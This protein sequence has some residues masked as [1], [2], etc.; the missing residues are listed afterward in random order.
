MSPHHDGSYK[1]R[2]RRHN[3]KYKGGG[4]TSRKKKEMVK[5]AKAAGMALHIAAYDAMGDASMVSQLQG[6]TLPMR[7]P[8]RPPPTPP[9][10]P[11]IICDNER[12]NDLNLNSKAK[13]HLLIEC[14]WKALSNNEES[15]RVKNQ[16][17]ELVDRAPVTQGE[18]DDPN[19]V[20]KIAV[21]LYTLA[22]SIN[23]RYLYQKLNE[24]MRFI[25]Q[26]KGT[27][28]VQTMY[29][30]WR[31]YI[32]SILKAAQPREE[33]DTT[34]FTLVRNQPQSY[35]MGGWKKGQRVKDN[36]KG[37]EGVITKIDDNNKR[38]LVNFSASGG[39][40]A[41]W[42]ERKSLSLVDG[43]TRHEDFWQS[44]MIISTSREMPPPS[45]F[46]GEASVE[47]VVYIFR[48]TNMALKIN[49]LSAIQSENE[50]IFLP[51]TT[52]SVIN[53]I[54]FKD[55]ESMI[56][57]DIK[58]ILR[59]QAERKT[60]S[61]LASTASKGDYAFYIK[62][63]PEKYG[64]LKMFLDAGY[65]DSRP[66]Q[67]R[68]SLDYLVN[69][70]TKTENGVV[71]VDDT[72]V[73]EVKDKISGE[74]NISNDRKN[75]LVFYYC[76]VKNM[77]ISVK[78]KIIKMDI[79]YYKNTGINQESDFIDKLYSSVTGIETV[80]GISKKGKKTRRRKK[81]SGKKTTG[82]KTTGKKTTGKKTTGK[83]TT[84]GGLRRGSRRKKTTRRHK[85]TNYE[86]YKNLILNY[87]KS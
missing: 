20:S 79:E 73:S 82:K 75:G 38:V 14:I 24:D 60:E 13:L 29:E 33:G 58:N 1:L 78:K 85:K 62:T 71:A 18:L 45:I 12:Y 86:L 48:D 26:A 41:V 59:P 22:D 46:F 16:V 66:V 9:T 28:D 81:T 52:F 53:T 4:R 35:N 77:D 36:K 67:D 65:L 80:G 34:R 39:K 50:Y 57:K 19:L 44:E 72:K 47:P 56:K 27:D 87:K 10:I 61:V 43:T 8:R 3:I 54:P 40:K 30:K 21:Y 15:R 25:F 84:G 74:L 55:I 32:I 5:A 11:E 2:D 49:H 17:C 42:C 37:N 31:E 6:A 7:P 69:Y 51:G 63:E 64:V 83:K 68:M 23:G 70:I 76:D